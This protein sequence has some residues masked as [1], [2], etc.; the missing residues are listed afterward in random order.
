MHRKVAVA[1]L[2]GDKRWAGYHHDVWGRNLRIS[3]FSSCADVL[4]GHRS[5]SMLGR[6]QFLVVWARVV[7]PSPDFVCGCHTSSGLALAE[8][9][10][11]LSLRFQRAYIQARPEKIAYHSSSQ[12]LVVGAV[13]QVG[14]Q[15]CAFT[16][17]H[18]T[19]PCRNCVNHSHAARSSPVGFAVDSFGSRQ[20]IAAAVFAARE[21]EGSSTTEVG[22][23]FVNAPRLPCLSCCPC[24]SS[25]R[26][27]HYGPGQERGKEKQIGTAPDVSHGF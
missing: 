15:R 12:T 8:L 17:Q 14:T 7:M 20:M 4:R 11:G 22:C 2:F 21:E 25:G 9:E 27:K 13:Q 19:L 18:R 1:R 23:G 24:A 26:R 3:S 5:L 10:T 16:M 6:A